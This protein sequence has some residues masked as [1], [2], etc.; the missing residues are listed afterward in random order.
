MMSVVGFT[1]VTFLVMAVLLGEGRSPI[2]P[3]IQQHTNHL[4]VR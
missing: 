1:A 2:L 4:M 3:R